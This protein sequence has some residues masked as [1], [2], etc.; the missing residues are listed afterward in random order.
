MSTV[1]NVN[2]IVTNRLVMYLDAANTRSY[3]GT[4]TT[5]TDLSQY[6]SNGTLTNGP[7]FSSTNGGGIV[8]DGTNNF[9]LLTSGAA[10]LTQTSN[11]TMEIWFYKTGTGLNYRLFYNGNSGANGYGFYTGVCSTPT[12]L[13]GILFGGVACNVVSTT[14]AINTWYHA[15]FTNTSGNVNTLY[16]NGVSVSTATQTYAAPTTETTIGAATNASNAYAGRIAIAKLYNRALTATEVLQN[17][18]S[19][20][21]RFG[22]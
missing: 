22:L 10:L 18:N 11:I 7:T 13:L 6:K 15:V 17:Y 3:P 9:V 8:F 5:W 21:A 14:V 4:G 12:T 20:K 19:T 16:L 1:Q 2:N